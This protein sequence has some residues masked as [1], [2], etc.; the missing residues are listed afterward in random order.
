MLFLMINP[1]V[2]FA[3]TKSNEYIFFHGQK[4]KYFDFSGNKIID[5]ILDHV[6]YGCTLDDLNAS[7]NKAGFDINQ[8]ERYLKFLIRHDLVVTKEIT[9]NMM[10]E[11]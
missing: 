4:F 2:G 6:D 7:T 10:L 5:F 1:S 8:V 9:Q 3:H 11:T